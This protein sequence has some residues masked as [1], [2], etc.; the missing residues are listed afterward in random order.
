MS[1]NHE[2][3]VRFDSEELEQLKIKSK[4]YGLKPAQ[5]IRLVVLSVRKLEM[6]Y[7]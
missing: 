7:E 5:Y 2:I 3:S 1:R 4:R 6:E